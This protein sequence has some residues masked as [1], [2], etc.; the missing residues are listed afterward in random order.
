MKNNILVIILFAIALLLTG[1]SNDQYGIEKQYW[2]VQKQAEKIFKN[3]HATP[4]MELDAAVKELSNFSRNNPKNKLSVD[5]EFDIARLYIVKEEFD[6]ARTQLKAIINKYAKSAPICSEALFLIGNSYQIQNNWNSALEQY[7]KIMQVYPITPR[8]MDTPVYIAQYYKIQYQPDK[9]I[10][11]FQ[12]AISHY[13]GLADKYPNSPLAFS[14][15][16]LVAQCYI[17]LKDWQDAINTLNS[18]IA[19]YKNKVNVDV[20]FIDIAALYGRELKDKVKAKETL[21]RLIKEYPHSR[22]VT[23]AGALIK[24]LEKK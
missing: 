11:A 3:P 23:T 5:A 10:A 1:C 8:G 22:L 15:Q 16:R 2:R 6:K 7:K 21:E 9:M 13:R 17:A 24:E 18:I 4:P 14:V 19:N 12:E 20:F